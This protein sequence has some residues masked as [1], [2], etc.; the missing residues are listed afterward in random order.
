MLFRSEKEAVAAGLIPQQFQ[1]YDN[2]EII[3]HTVYSGIVI[4]YQGKQVSIPIILSSDNLE[5]QVVTSILALVYPSE[6]KI[7]IIDGTKKLDTDYSYFK[8]W[9]LQS[10]YNVIVLT[11][12]NL[13]DSNFFSVLFVIG[14]EYLSDEQM[15]FI[16][17]WSNKNK[18]L[19]FASSPYIIDATGNWNIKEKTKRFLFDALLQKN[20]LYSG[21]SLILDNSNV[22]IAI[23]NENLGTYEYINYPLWPYVLKS[24]LNNDSKIT[25]NISSLVFNWPGAIYFNDFEPEHYV[26]FDIKVLAKT[27]SKSWEMTE[28]LNT[29]PYFTYKPNLQ[30]SPYNLAVS[31][32]N[33]NSRSVYVADEY[34]FSN[35]IEWSNSVENLDF[36]SSAVL[37]L[38]GEDDI[39]SLQKK[40]AMPTRLSF[41]GSKEEQKNNILVM[42]LIPVVFIPVLLFVFALFF[43]LKK[44]SKK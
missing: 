16:E 14:D 28:S 42:W 23:Q 26:N 11:D 15:Y 37:W 41:S 27:G 1:S 40:V 21:S 34:F 19:F 8:E 29:D 33:N 31:I 32:E 22:R 12:E 10:R 25:A 2:T 13:N 9:L 6:K 4:E 3:Y 30:T 18:P 43:Y 20:G 38:E 17:N 7:G 36:I 44:G 35:A 39:L 5:Y 24:N